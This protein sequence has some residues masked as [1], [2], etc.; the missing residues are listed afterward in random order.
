MKYV[1]ILDIG[2]V[3]KQSGLPASTLRYYEEKGLIQSIGRRGLRRLFEGNIL[4]Q[5][6]LI[7]L[8][9]QA[10]FSLGE[11]SQM[12]VIDGKLE[13]DRALLMSKADEIDENIKQLV[14]VRDGLIHAAECK[15]P[16]HLE[17][18]SFQ[19]LLNMA[20]KNRVRVSKF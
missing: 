5:L 19:R 20:R 1:E 8:G 15:A 3:V 11:I 6:A 7:S 14:A 12:F 13:I 9:R 17:C 18:P 2:E 4:Q 10:G 16:S